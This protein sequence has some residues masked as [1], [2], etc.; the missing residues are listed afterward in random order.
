MQTAGGE[1]FKLH[2]YA[3]GEVYLEQYR[4]GAAKMDVVHITLGWWERLVADVVERADTA[5]DKQEL[6]DGFLNA[7]VFQGEAGYAAWRSRLLPYPGE[8]AVRMVE[9][10][11]FFYPPWVMREH[12]VARDDW[13]SFYSH[14]TAAVR[15]L[16]GI[17]AGLN[18]IYV[19]TEAAK[20]PT[21]IFRRMTIAPA[22]LA[23]R[24]EAL[25]LMDRSQ[26]PDTLATLV[27]EVLD[28]VEKHLPQVDVG[29]ARQRIGFEMHPCHSRPA[30]HPLADP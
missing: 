7:V 21:E 17:Q 6:I 13:L 28:L 3:P 12:D 26:V 18:R 9:R 22:E 27:S 14:L 19:S 15:N 2:Q 30:F 10:H 20:R 25:W 16:L 29:T 24:V 23:G 11:L 1:R 8:L 5:P 4:I